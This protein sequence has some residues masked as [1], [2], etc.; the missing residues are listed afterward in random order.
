MHSL[1]EIIGVILCVTGQGYELDI[2]TESTL[3]TGVIRGWHNKGKREPT[4]NNAIIYLFDYANGR[5]PA[6][7][8]K[9]SPIYKFSSLHS[10]PMCE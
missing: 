7:T 6:N 1:K 2:T 5:I 4:I 8:K 10:M 3:F 9:L